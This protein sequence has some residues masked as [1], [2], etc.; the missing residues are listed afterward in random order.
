[1]GDIIFYCGIPVDLSNPTMTASI[2]SKIN[3]IHDYIRAENGVQQ[4]IMNGHEN[5]RA[6]S[7]IKTDI[8]PYRI[9]CEIKEKRVTLGVLDSNSQ[10]FIVP[11]LSVLDLSNQT[12]ASIAYNSGKFCKFAILGKTSIQ[13]KMEEYLPAWDRYVEQIHQSGKYVDRTVDM[14]FINKKDDYVTSNSEL[15]KAVANTV[16]PI[17]RKET[18]KS[19]L[20]DRPDGQPYENDP[21]RYQREIAALFNPKRKLTDWSKETDVEKLRN[22]V[23]FSNGVINYGRGLDALKIIAMNKH[24]PEESLIEIAGGKLDNQGK[25]MMTNDNVREIWGYVLKNE[26]CP[27]EL[28]CDIFIETLLNRDKMNPD[29]YKGMLVEINRFMKGHGEEKLAGIAAAHWRGSI[30]EKQALDIT[31]KAMETAGIESILHKPEAVKEKEF[32]DASKE[33]SEHTQTITP[34]SDQNDILPNL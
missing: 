10:K 17:S 30:D 34:N 21:E 15:R 18:L 24:L 27:K 29:F 16:I 4:Y 28:A 11:N 19:I 8:E 3:E 25:S 9:V 1:M 26:N 12:L 20:S 22:A 2:V 33:H 14:G 7:Q 13:P 32:V 23:S 6:I 5:S 31:M